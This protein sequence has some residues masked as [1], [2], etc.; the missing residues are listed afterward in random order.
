MSGGRGGAQKIPRPPTIRLGGAAPWAGLAPEAIALPLDEVRRR[1]LAFPEPQ[2][3]P[4]VPGMQAAAVLV[5]LF[6]ADGETSGAPGTRAAMLKQC[7]DAT[8]WLFKSG[9]E[10]PSSSANNPIGWSVIPRA[11]AS[12]SGHVRRA[13]FEHGITM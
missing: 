4:R 7:S 10:R 2:R 11:V 6:E 9:S 1:C 8:R 3:P 12:A 13:Q 5:P